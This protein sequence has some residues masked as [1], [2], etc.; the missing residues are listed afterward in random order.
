MTGRERI[1]SFIEEYGLE[2]LK[3]LT[4]V[5]QDKSEAAMRKSIRETPDGIYENVIKGDGLTDAL[6]NGSSV[7]VDL[8]V[9]RSRAWLAHP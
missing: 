5:V 7:F 1:K 2:D 9:R 6:S 4:T 8:S 3:A